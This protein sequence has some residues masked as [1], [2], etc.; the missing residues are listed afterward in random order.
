[1]LPDGIIIRTNN[2]CEQLECLNTALKRKRPTLIHCKHMVFHKDNAWPHIV[3][4]SVMVIGTENR[5]GR[6]CSIPPKAVAFPLP[7]EKT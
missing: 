2:Y 6:L 7:L 1:M 4:G 3:K 5:T